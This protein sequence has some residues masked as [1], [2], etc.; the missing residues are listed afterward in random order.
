MAAEAIT[1][2]SDSSAEYER[3]VDMFR[4]SPPSL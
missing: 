2:D 1:A 3:V 4:L